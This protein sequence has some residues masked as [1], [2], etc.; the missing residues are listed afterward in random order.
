LSVIPSLRGVQAELAKGMVAPA[1]V[2][3]E[4][5]GAAAGAG[6]TKGLAARMSAARL[7]ALGKTLTK[8]VTLPLVGIG[9]AAIHA[10]DS[11]GDAQDNIRVKTGATGKKLQG[12]QAVFRDVAKQ[13]PE[14]FSDVSDAVSALNVTTGATGKTL[15]KMSTDVLEASRV[16]G[17]DG[18]KNAKAFGQ[19]LQQFG[20]SAKDGDQH[21]QVLFRATQKFGLGMGDALKSMNKYG[22]VLSSVGFSMDQTIGLF[23][24]MNKAGIDVRRTMPGLNQAFRK[25]AQAGKD[26]QKMLAVTIDKMRHAKSGTQALAIATK[27]FGS[28]GAA[29]LTAAVRKSGLSFDNL[30][31]SLQKGGDTIGRT[32]KSVRTL[33]EQLA[34]L[35]NNVTLALAPLGQVLFPS[36]VKGIKMFLAPLSAM[37]HLFTS[38]P[39]PIKG[40]VTTM[41]GFLA[42]VGPALI[43]VSKLSRAVTAFKDAMIA[44]KIAVAA[45]IIVQRA[46]TAAQVAFDAAMDANPLVIVTA[47]IVTLGAAIYE[48]VKHFHTVKKAVVTAF[49]TVK[50]AI[51]G[52]FQWVK[53]HLRT[54]VPIIATLITGPVGGA[55]AYVVTHW[56]QVK[57]VTAKVW[58]AIRTFLGTIWHGVLTTATTMWTA[59]KT[60]ILTPARA[61]RDVLA[62]VW[63]TIHR[64]AR[65]AWR[66]VL[67]TAGIVWGAIRTAVLTPARGARTVLGRV[68]GDIKTA[69]GTAWGDI[70]TKAGRVWP[71]IS[72]A[73]AGPIKAAV[74]DVKR[75]IGIGK[76]NNNGLIQDLSGAWKTIKGGVGDFAGHLG[77][78]VL[79]AVRG[80]INKVIGFINIIIKGL[81]HLPFVKIGTISKIKSGSKFGRA[82]KHLVGFAHG[83]VTERGGLVNRPGVVWGEDAPRWPEYVVPTNPA[84]KTRAHGL[85]AQAAQATGMPGLASGGTLS[86][87]QIEKLWTAAGGDP[88]KANLMAAIAEAESRGNPRAYNP[89]GATGLWQIL[90][91]PN[92][93]RYW[94]GNTNFTNPVVN[95][96]AAVQKL[97][98]QGLGAWQTYTNGAYKQFLGGGGGGILGAIGH[99]LSG[100]VSGV[101][102]FMGGLLSKGVGWAAGKIKGLMPDLG[103]LPG[104]LHG[105]GKW[106]VDKALGWAKG[107]IGGLFG[108]GGGGAAGTHMMDGKPVADWIYAILERARQ[109]GVGFTVSSGFRTDA[110]Q[111]RI[112]DS[113]VRPA[114]VP[115]SEGGP[116]SNH[117]GSRFPA[118]AVDISPGAG[119]L[120][121][122][123]RKVGLASR[124][125]YAGAKDPV[126]F[127]HPHGGGYAAGTRSALPGWRWVGERGPEQV[128]FRG[129]EQVLSHDESVAAAGRGTV[130]VEGD[131]V[132]SDRQDA[133]LV[134][135]RLAWQLAAA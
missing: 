110:E 55:V 97:H 98:D 69:A 26:P 70:K 40:V 119:A 71:K 43:V 37:G 91:A 80:A 64:V 105:A 127:S 59:I 38:L 9:A 108:L 86:K 117:E 7:G 87:G 109:A 61:A 32:G 135:R 52:A 11:V 104:W 17:E 115:K 122:W 118:G 89:S 84:H 103:S 133:D 41:G 130:V 10:A 121:A 128:N 45:G 13:G 19:S 77:S 1:A 57:A 8:A 35:K 111:T 39:G 50:H 81:N 101:G 5:A 28:Q 68:W 21:L 44:Q 107:K 6:V 66:G 62:A 23:G 100:A 46:A 15:G 88:S 29:T 129:G 83:G 125:V 74:E 124:L 106:L 36:L 65:V 96:H 120:A 22:P 131:L 113:G 33:G 78:T 60:A 75:F 85:I 132:V 18:A 47:A 63:Q 27:S 72:A 4:K 48:L 25:W 134:A 93:G 31:K 94:H 126:H 114:A 42:A 82:V 16:L 20:I 56:D 99:A 116:G 12:L 24:R 51:V 53:A 95:A 58:G 54:I 67:G 92:R 123:L 79:N 49:S 2:A 90:G 3:G 73:I 102:G 34:T 30:G 14:S 76:G 112:Y